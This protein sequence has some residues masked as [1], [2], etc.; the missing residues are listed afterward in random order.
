VR[1]LPRRQFRGLLDCPLRGLLSRVLLCG[2]LSRVLLCGLL[3]CPLCR[4]FRGLSRSLFRCLPGGLLRR[5]FGSVFGSLRLQCG[6]L[7]G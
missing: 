7:R 6:P 4:L 1:L 2:F 5:S 3:G